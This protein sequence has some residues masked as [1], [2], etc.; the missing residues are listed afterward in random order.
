MFR[1][2]LPRFGTFTAFRDA[3]RLLASHRIPGAEVQWAR[4]GAPQGLFDPDPLPASTGPHEVLA[5][6]DFLN[7][8]AAVACHSAADGLPT[9]YQALLRL[10]DDRRFLANPADPIGAGLAR[11]AKSVRRDIH[12][13]HAFVRF[14][15]LP[16]PGP[17]RAFAAWFEPQHLILEAAAPFFVKRFA[18]MDWLI[19]TPEGTVRFDGHLSLDPPEARPDLPTDAG[20]DLW[21]VY[22]R[23]IFNP[24]R[25]MPRAMRSEMP[26]KY[27][28]NLPEARAIA[29]MIAQAPARVA[30]MQA[31]GATVAPARAL[32]M[33]AR[34]RKAA[35]VTVPQTMAEAQAQAAACT[36]CAL[37]EAATQT[38]WGAGDPSAALMIVGEAPGDH[39][40]LQGRPFIGPAGQLLRQLMAKAGLTPDRVWLT[41]AVK[42][43]KFI[44][45]GKK[46]LHQ[47]PNRS[48][49][50]HCRPWLG[51]ERRM[52]APRLTL[53]L[54]AT[55]A[56][57]LTGDSAPLI[58]RRG[59]IERAQDGG[60]VLISWH[61]SAILRA[62]GNAAALHAEL[63]ADLKHA[64]DLIA[65]Q[66][67]QVPAPNMI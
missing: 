61:P 62:S 42:H 58:S 65:D 18:D 3:A 2:E 4:A 41:N 50:D 46:R 49:V 10:Q 26:V 60:P 1:V 38:V 34:A 16:A 14:F 35:V 13:M 7:L 55:A 66:E 54:G 21:Q 57:A 28:K 44:P 67:Y 15:E 9:L 32:R 45:R 27:W 22:F 63:A 8:A 5:T 39:E 23:N 36:G 43:F 30:A 12:K 25:L 59:R 52:I 33:A 40:D 37:C 24:A 29:D 53:A 17:R 19:A 47:N 48:E 11:L 20:H 6:R 31:A 64:A 56:Y 51:I